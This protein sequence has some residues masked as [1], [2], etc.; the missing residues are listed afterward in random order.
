MNLKQAKEQGKLDE[1][2]NEQNTVCLFGG[3]NGG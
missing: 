2:I 1:F 3:L